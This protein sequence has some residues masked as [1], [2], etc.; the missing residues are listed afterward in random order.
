VLI[1][2]LEASLL[3][4][5]LPRTELADAIESHK[6]LKERRGNAGGRDELRPGDPDRTRE[7]RNRPGWA[8]TRLVRS[9]DE[10]ERTL[11]WI[12]R[13]RTAPAAREQGTPRE[14]EPD[15]PQEREHARA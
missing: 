13:E 7:L 10:Y 4:E 6:R 5:E 8:W 11:E 15:T 3:D 14:R 12:E 1:A 2:H 9:Y